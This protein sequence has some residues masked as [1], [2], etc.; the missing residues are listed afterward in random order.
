MSATA[1]AVAVIVLA[2]G[3]AR[4]WSA[5][6]IGA[7][8]LSNPSFEYDDATHGG[9][10]VAGGVFALGNWGPGPQDGLFFYHSG[11]NNWATLWQELDLAAMGYDPVRLATGGYWAEFSGYQVSAAE[12]WPSLYDQGL[13][14]LRQY[15]P[16]EVENGVT[17][18]DWMA[19][20]TWVQKQGSVRLA[21]NT[22]K[23]RYL[24]DAQRLD[25]WGGNNDAYLDNTSLMLKEYNIWTWGT[26][27]HDYLGAGPWDVGFDYVTINGGAAATNGAV[28]RTENGAVVGGAIHLDGGQWFSGTGF[29]AGFGSVGVMVG[30]AGVSGEVNVT[31]GGKWS[32]GRESWVGIL[33]GAGGSGT[34]NVS[35]PSLWATDCGVNVGDKRAGEVNLAPGALW[36]SNGE[37]R[38][39]AGSSSSAVVNV[40]GGTWT[41]T[42]RILVGAYQG[43]PATV[44]IGLG[45]RWNT[46]Y[47]VSVGYT[48]TGTV[49]VNVNGQWTSSGIVVLGDRAGSSGQVTVSRGAW[50]V[51]GPVIV[52][53]RGSG[54]LTIA[55]GDVVV[56][57]GPLTV[58][59]G[60]ELVITN[61]RLEVAGAGV[62]NVLSA[63]QFGDS[64]SIMLTGGY[65]FHAL[66]NLDLNGGMILGNGAVHVG[67]AGVHLG[68][69]GR[70]GH[71]A[72]GSLA[73]PLSVYGNVSGSGSIQQVTV[74]GHADVGTPASATGGVVTIGS[75]VSVTGNV[76][77][78]PGNVL[79]INGDLSADRVAVTGGT[80]TN[81]VH[82][83]GRVT[84]NG[85]VALTDGGT[86][87]VE[88]MGARTDRLVGAADVMLGPGASLEIAMMGGGEEFVGGTYT[89]IDVDGG[90][91]G[92]FANV[93]DLGA[94]VSVNG[95]GLTYDEAAGTVT[96]TLDM[97]LNPGDAN[98]DGATDVLDRIAW[99]NH[100]FTSGTTFV[101]GDFNA[102]GVTDV[103][104]RII[105]SS[106]N[107]T[108]ATAGPAPPGATTDPIPEP[109]TISLLALGALAMLRRKQRSAAF[110]RNRS[111]S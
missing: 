35:G 48:G 90:V 69:P 100:N 41:A 6:A 40:S 65:L 34:V 42:D 54:R 55:D 13:I 50:T 104:D 9:W 86:L 105:W 87:A 18:L 70:T 27:S 32:H 4:A 3:G 64:G 83:A 2:M 51:D 61:G 60:G 39:A 73:G 78:G 91:S 1:F 77:V 82:G 97:N 71:L 106:H 45:G 20:T 44:N 88:A 29:V 110:G 92:T 37:V 103:S 8:I 93:T 24:F 14:S 59:T 21:T 46:F 36:N 75:N 98:L 56:R 49:N 31:G 62:V 68:S 72:G 108:L 43:R 111:P 15:T 23:L 94:Y 33:I 89:L 11:A 58:R 52:A 96:L 101:T 107:F 99:N 53:S 12:A 76:T 10:Q 85:S 63:I 19:W 95:D 66:E 38:M 7:N 81:P 25:I 5:P 26:N 80:L 74:Y 84:V 30:Q 57:G 22:T 28:M 67:S 109:A 47:D 102:D 16:A 79:C 17:F